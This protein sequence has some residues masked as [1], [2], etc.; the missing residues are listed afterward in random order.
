MRC[1]M[2]LLAAMI[3]SAPMASQAG[4]VALG[5]EKAIKCKQCH[6]LDGIGKM[7]NFP[8]IAGQKEAYLAAQLKAYR[9]GS[10]KDEMMS[11]ISKDLSDE[12]IANLAAYYAA[13]KV[14]LSLPDR[15]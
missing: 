12:D 1:Y 9:A 3:A 2:T 11:F 4:D 13:I 15:D 5:R 7:A 10:R 14:T 8:N 6:G